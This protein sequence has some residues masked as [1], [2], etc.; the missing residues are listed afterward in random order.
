MSFWN[1]ILRRFRRKSQ[2]PDEPYEPESVLD[3]ILHDHTWYKP[4]ERQDN[5]RTPGE[6]PKQSER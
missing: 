1:F 2:P 6:D 3:D 5:K 4:Y